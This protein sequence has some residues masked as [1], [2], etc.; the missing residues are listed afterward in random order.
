MSTIPTGAGVESMDSIMGRWRYL[1]KLVGLLWR[2]AL[3]DLVL[4]GV[5][6]L[7]SGLVPLAA[8][9]VLRGLVDSAVDL[10]TGEGELAAALIWAG[11]LLAV[12]L[13]ENALGEVRDWLSSEVRDRISARME[14]RLL[15]RAGSLGSTIVR[16]C[17][18]SQSPVNPIRDAILAVPCCVRASRS[19]RSATPG[20]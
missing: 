20:S 13:V 18:A 19:L 17:K 8:V 6:S 11:A 15:H 4:I 10:I 12:Y 9:L 2:V 7:V 5:P 1:P 3:S 14:E 16:S